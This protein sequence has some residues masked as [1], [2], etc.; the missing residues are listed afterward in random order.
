MAKHV[1]SRKT[2]QCKSHHQKIIKIYR[3]VDAIITSYRQK[4]SKLNA[5][6][7]LFRDTEPRVL[8]NAFA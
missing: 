1:R 6:W 3:T 7:K 2:S 5:E 8:L 4:Y